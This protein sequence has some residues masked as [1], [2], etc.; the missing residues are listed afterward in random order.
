MKAVYD[1]AAALAAKREEFVLATVVHT[2]GSTPQKPGATLL[3]RA[4]GSTVGTLGGGCV[5]GDIWAAAKE[6]LRERE[7]PSYKDYYL[8]E[9]IAAQDGLVCG[10][11]M[12]FYIEP[13]LGPES[14]S[15]LADEIAEAYRGGPPLAVATVVTSKNG[16][17]GNRLVARADGS[18]DGSLGTAALDAEATA[19]A[20]AVMHMGKSERIETAGGDEVFVAGYTSPM[21]LVLIGGGHVNLQVAKIAEILGFRV[22]V[23]DDRPEFANEERFGMAEAVSVAPYDKGLDAFPINRNTAIV[24]GTRGHNFDDSAL[25]AAVRTDAA[26]VGLLGSK[27]KTIL[28]YE[29][30]L[31][32]GISPERLKAVHSPVGLDLGGRTPEEI[33]LSITSEIVAFWYGHDGGTMKIEDAQVERISKKLRGAAAR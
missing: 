20:N 22:M 24:V 10:G 28:I 11:S 25:E 17:A 7:A 33:A 1:E 30:L 5:E 23:T 4:D 3:V 9:E 13:V 14:F 31:K 16:R 29:A 15:P 2:R 27:R 32:R 8:N 26:Y 19:A 12:F 18:T 6:A 21:L